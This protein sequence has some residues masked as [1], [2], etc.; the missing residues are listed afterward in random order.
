MLLS[1][2]CQK[3]SLFFELLI[4]P[5]CIYANK[6]LDNGFV[7]MMIMMMSAWFDDLMINYLGVWTLFM[8]MWILEILTSCGFIVGIRRAWID[9]NTLNL[10]RV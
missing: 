7:G 2:Q 3:T 8:L 9:R 6:M 5:V 1:Y 4:F 10:M